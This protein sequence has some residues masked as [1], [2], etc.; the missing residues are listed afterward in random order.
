MKSTKKSIKTR[1]AAVAIAAISAF[2]VVGMASQSAFAAEIPAWQEMGYFTS[3][4]DFNA[5]CE[6]YAQDPIH[7]GVYMWI[8]LRDPAHKEWSKLFP[9]ASY[10]VYE[11][12]EDIKKNATVTLDDW[13][14]SN[15]FMFGAE[16][17]PEYDFDDLYNPFLDYMWDKYLRGKNYFCFREYLDKNASTIFA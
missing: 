6:W 3:E 14:L 1:I 12:M 16:G 10:F 8:W 4:E 15:D 13:D 5:F 17:Y 11:I 7:N 2:S 9:K